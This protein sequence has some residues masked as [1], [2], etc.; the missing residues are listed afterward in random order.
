VRSRRLQSVFCDRSELGRVNRWIVLRFLTIALVVAVLLLSSKSSLFKT[1]AVAQVPTQSMPSNP[2]SALAQKDFAAIPDAPTAISSAQI[3]PAAGQTPEYCS[4]KGDVT[5][6]IQFEMRLPT[7][8]WNHRYLQVGCGGYCG[9]LR[10]SPESNVALAQNFA[11]A[12][13]NSGHVG[14]GLGA[15]NTLWG[16]D[17]PQLRIDFGYR[18][19][20]VLSF[21]SPML[22]L[23]IIRGIMSNF[24]FKVS[25][26]LCCRLESTS[27]H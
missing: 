10:A 14:G 3:I 18:S 22:L 21:T 9:S 20:R 19:N 27:I 23:P 15:G 5:P 24:P 2:C 4:V 12:F 26:T 17:Q 25:T 16:L 1:S 7:Q 11:V 6:Q 13:D 8:N